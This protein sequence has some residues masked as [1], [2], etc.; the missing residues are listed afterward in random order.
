MFAKNNIKIIGV[1]VV[2]QR[3]MNLTSIHEDSGLIPGFAQW[4]KESSVAM[5]CSVGQGC[6]SDSIVAVALA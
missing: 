6:G 5:S 4:V 3:F 1:P 2:A